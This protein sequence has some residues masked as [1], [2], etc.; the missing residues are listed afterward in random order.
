MAGQRTGV[1]NAQFTGASIPGTEKKVNFGNLSVFSNT[2]RSTSVAN[3]EGIMHL[4]LIDDVERTFDLV[5]KHGRKKIGKCLLGVK[6]WGFDLCLCRSGRQHHGIT[7]MEMAVN[8]PFPGSPKRLS[9]LCVGFVTRSS[10]LIITMWGD[11]MKLKI[12]LEP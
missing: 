11:T 6:A 10:E 12:I 8:Q 4:P 1:P 9:E 7:G 5:L 2:P 3:R